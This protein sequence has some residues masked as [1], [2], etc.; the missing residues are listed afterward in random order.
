MASTGIQSA[1]LFEDIFDVVK[2]NPDGKKFE[3]GA[4]SGALSGGAWAEREGQG[5]CAGGGAAR[6][7]VGALGFAVDRG[8]IRA[9]GD[10]RAAVSPTWWSSH[11]VA[12]ANRTRGEIAWP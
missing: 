11:T 12:W 3:R 6:S 7:R 2:I 8:D 10:R 1:T 4:S 9:A 5:G